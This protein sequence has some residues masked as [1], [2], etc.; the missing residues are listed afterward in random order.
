MMGKMTAGK[1]PRTRA[2]IVNDNEGQIG[3]ISVFITSSKSAEWTCEGEY[4]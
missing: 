2:I 1:I 3:P 4:R